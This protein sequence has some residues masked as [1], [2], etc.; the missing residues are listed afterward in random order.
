LDG[1]PNSVT[2]DFFDQGNAVMAKKYGDKFPWKN[3]NRLQQ[4]EIGPGIILK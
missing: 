2:K 3:G 1:N 4:I